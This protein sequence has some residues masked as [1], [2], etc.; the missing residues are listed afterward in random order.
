M[1]VAA[2]RFDEPTVIP[3]APSPSSSTSTPIGTTSRASAS[4]DEHFA[5]GSGPTGL[6]P[7]STFS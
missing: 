6:D 5:G 3:M 1:L 4:Y 7:P 2:I